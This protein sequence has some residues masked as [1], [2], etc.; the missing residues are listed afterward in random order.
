MASN[1]KKR[2][3]VLGASCILAALI[4][5]GSTFAWFTSR[6]EVTNRLHANGEYGVSVVESYDPPA[7]WLPGQLVEKDVYATNTGS[8]AAFVREDISGVLTV[9]TESATAAK[10]A[11]S[12]K[13]T[14]EEVFVKEA[15]ASLAFK[16]AASAANLGNI[17]VVRADDQTTPAK[18]TFTPDAEG[19]YVFKRTVKVAANGTETYSYDGYY[20]V[21]AAGEGASATP[22][23]YYKISNL[24]VTADNNAGHG[25]LSA[26]TAGFA[27][28][29]QAVVDPVAMNYVAA[30]RTLVATYD[31][32]PA[33]DENG[34]ITVNIKL[35]DS[36]INEANNTADKWLLYNNPAND[37]KAIFF[38]TGI[39]EG[40]ETSAKLVDSVTLDSSV[41]ADT[42]KTFDFDLNVVLTSAQI[43][44][45]S[46]NKTI[47]TDAT[48]ELTSDLAADKK[49]T[50]VDTQSLDTA[51]NWN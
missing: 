26:A 28:D 47:L 4:V 2:R 9:T 25:L 7:E 22:A 32:K 49:A 11:N 33:D 45:A 51:V 43:T 35:S 17:T 36:V 44:Y 48:V 15:G 27:E 20:F 6:D 19:L 1:S 5:A 14:T 23:A 30:T 8:V 21:P 42:Y 31:T 10:T 50:L 39:L 38:Y 34:L 46:D 40:G 16:P 3:R 13:L 24:Q 18:T 12:I 41:K 37:G 29:V